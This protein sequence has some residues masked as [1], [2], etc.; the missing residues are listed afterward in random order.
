MFIG[1]LKIGTKLVLT[2]IFVVLSCML[3][4]S[5]VVGY[6]SNSILQ[7]ESE[8]LLMNAAKRSANAI[9]AS[10][11]SSY[12]S[13]A[14]TQANLQNLI[15]SDMNDKEFIIEQEISNMADALRSNAFSF[16]YLK[17]SGLFK[18]SK[19]E[20]GN[21]EMMMLTYDSTPGIKGG[22][23]I[24]GASEEI[25]GWDKV[26]SAISSGTQTIVCHIILR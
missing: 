17:N 16:I 23:I 19:Y 24:S 5:F 7:I 20:F 21:D 12:A 10:L 9:N 14:L 3:A 25:L 8:K 13:L 18:G 22:V 2:I 1:N 15:L 6:K 11:Q 4:L 26:R